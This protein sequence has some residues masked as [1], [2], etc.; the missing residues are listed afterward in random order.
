MTTLY[1]NWDIKFRFHQ[2]E[3][4]LRLQDINFVVLNFDKVLPI[5]NSG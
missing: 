1:V 3:C 5:D 2:V 4:C